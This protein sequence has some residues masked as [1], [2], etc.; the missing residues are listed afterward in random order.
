MYK[1]ITADTLF[2][3]WLN[4]IRDERRTRA[5]RTRMRRSLDAMDVAAAVAAATDASDCWA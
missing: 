2:E 5:I 4:E 3:K 1:L